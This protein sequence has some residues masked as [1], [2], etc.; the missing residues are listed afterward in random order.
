MLQQSPP[1]ARDWHYSAVKRL[2]TLSSEALPP[3]LDLRARLPAVRDQGPEGA[4]AAFAAA[5]VKEAQE[6]VDVGMRSH[7]S[8]RFVY[9][10]RENKPA[11]GM[12][13][14]DVMQILQRA[15]T[16]TEAACPY[17]PNE[18]DKAFDAAMQEE[19]ARF[20]IARYALCD[21]L[22]AIK[23]ALVHQGP[24]IVAL[25]AYNYGAAFWRQ[26]TPQEPMLGG[27]AVACVGYDNARRALLLRNS[28]GAGWNGGGYAW[29]PY[30]DWGT[31]W[32]V[33]SSVDAESG[34]PAQ[35]QPQPSP[36]VDPKGGCRCC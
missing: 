33:W 31:Q 14:R 13:L 29:F 11:E 6:F 2:R 27:H 25:P 32:E 8:P 17:A 7:M 18:P 15:G 21:T 30:A 36:V 26:S 3:T 35:P 34:D 20:V 9:A 10:R 12:Y 1:D 16:C 4:C 28:W 22:D 19:A 23:H 5:V 24:C